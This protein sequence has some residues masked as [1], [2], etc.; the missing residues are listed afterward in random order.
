MKCYF[1]NTYPTSRQDKNCLTL[2]HLASSNGK[3]QLPFKKGTCSLISIWLFLLFYYY[4]FQVYFFPLTLD[5]LKGFFLIH[6]AFNVGI[7]CLSNIFMLFYFL[8]T[9]FYFWF[10]VFFIGVKCCFTVTLI[11]LFGVFSVF[12]VSHRGGTNMHYR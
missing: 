11:S 7:W 5:L 8:I 6:F 9:V 10:T 3:E 4:L 12:Y 1:I 2:Q